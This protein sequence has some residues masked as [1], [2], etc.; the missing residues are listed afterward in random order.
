MVEPSLTAISKP[1]PDAQDLTTQENN[2]AN[3]TH[4][5]SVSTTLFSK[6]LA[7]L[8]HELCNLVEYCT[9]TMHGYLI[10]KK[11]WSIRVWR[12]VP[13]ITQEKV[14]SRSRHFWSWVFSRFDVS[15]HIYLGMLMSDPCFCMLFKYYVSYRSYQSIWC[16]MHVSVSSLNPMCRILF[17]WACLLSDACFCIFSKYCVSY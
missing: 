7:P 16:Q 12:T 10:N 6:P 14:A 17:I 11:M 13:T 3:L 8:K 5:L 4:P 1:I 9:G 15:Y 2:E